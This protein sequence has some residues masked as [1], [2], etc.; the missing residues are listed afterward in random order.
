MWAE[1]GVWSIDLHL[2]RQVSMTALPGSRACEA[3]SRSAQQTDLPGSAAMNFASRA[4]TASF[5]QHCSHKDSVTSVQ[6]S[7]HVSCKISLRTQI[8][9]EY[10]ACP[11]AVQC[12]C[13][14]IC[15]K[16]TGTT[17]K[18]SGSGD[19]C[20][21]THQHS[22]VPSRQLQCSP[23]LLVDSAQRGCLQLGGLQCDACAECQL[24]IRQGLIACGL[25]D[26]SPQ[27]ATTAFSWR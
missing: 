25:C 9:R 4:S 1:E 14:L 12:A 17:L 15:P 5:E 11:A 18:W 3:C 23:E 20:F 22:Q 2:Y 6:H 21:A 8:P 19:I 16:I 10:K 7:Q 27:K 24:C 26:C 13:M